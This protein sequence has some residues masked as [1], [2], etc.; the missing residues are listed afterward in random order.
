MKETMS[1]VAVFNPSKVPAFLQGRTELSAM[2][3]ALA[4]GA[5]GGKR[6][7]IKGGVFRLIVDGEEVSAI[8]ERHLDVVLVNAAAEIGRVF[9]MKE[10][11]PDNDPTSPDCWSA[12]GETPSKDIAHPQSTSCATCTMNIAG[13]GKGDSRACRFQQ[14]LAVV[15]ADEI[16]GDVM[17]LSAP[18]TSVFGKEEGSNRPLQAYA[19]W[20]AAQN[21]SPETVVT[22]MRFDTK[23]ENPKL[24]F[25]AVRYVTD[26]EFAA[27]QTQAKSDDALTAI[28]MSFSQNASKPPADALQGKRPMGDLTREEDAPAYEPIAAKAAKKAKPAPVIEE[29]DEEEAPPPPKATRKAKPAP[30][31]EEEEETPEP[32]VRKSA[33]KETAVPTKKSSLASIVADWDDE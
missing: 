22:R 10:W 12:D 28:E 23:A 6:V 25:S 7:S 1:N 21:V 16:E 13:S 15:L 18:A 2:A 26:E 20:L 29:D 19:R 11:S 33:A 3:K 9:Y 24:F 30:V 31:V 27:I 17:Q 4:G 5:A 32:P 14:R 8:D